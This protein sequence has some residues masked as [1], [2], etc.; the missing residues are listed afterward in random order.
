M[1]V[2]DLDAAIAGFRAGSPASGEG[3]VPG[4]WSDEDWKELFRFTSTR[5]IKAG[6]MLIRRGDPDRT[7]YFVLSGDL[8]VV[9]HSADGMSMG[10]LT[11]IGAGCVL[12]EQSF[13]DGSP[14]SASVWAT[15]HCDVAAMSP[16][17]YAALEVASPGLARDLLFALGR[18]LAIRLRRTTAKVIG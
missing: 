18:V 15:D 5:R 14:R 8:E 3:L 2:T 7:L 9:V 16:E 4:N 10:P 6:D 11:R 12:G 1:S 17:Q 13:F